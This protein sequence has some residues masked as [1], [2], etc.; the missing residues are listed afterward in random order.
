MPDA[1]IGLQTQ[2]EQMPDNW[3]FYEIVFMSLS[4]S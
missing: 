2:E 3:A 4:M 1:G